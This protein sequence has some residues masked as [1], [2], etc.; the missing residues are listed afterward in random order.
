MAKVNGIL[1][2]IRDNYRPI[3]TDRNNTTEFDSW[4]DNMLEQIFSCGS[5]K[6]IFWKRVDVDGQAYLSTEPSEE[7]KEMLRDFLSEEDN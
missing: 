2:Y 3:T 7:Q 5:T 4:L 6:Q 1:P